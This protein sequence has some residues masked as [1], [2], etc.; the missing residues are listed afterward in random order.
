MKITELSHYIDLNKYLNDYKYCILKFSATWCG[1]CQKISN[2]LKT[3]LINY[4][5]DN[6]IIINIDYDEHSE[7][8]ENYGITQLPTLF[9]IENN[10]II[11]KIIGTNLDILYNFLGL[12]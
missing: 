8:A 7:V 12:T 3:K 1:P 6:T 9:I 11:N 10:N 2:E 4:N 5:N